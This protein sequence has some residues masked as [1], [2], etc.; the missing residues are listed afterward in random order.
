MIISVLFLIKIVQFLFGKLYTQNNDKKNDVSFP[1]V[2]FHFLHIGTF[3]FYG[4]LIV[5][6]ARVCNDVLDSNECNLCIT[7]KLLS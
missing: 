1:I 2:K 5:R 7:R 3:T 6:D 4:V